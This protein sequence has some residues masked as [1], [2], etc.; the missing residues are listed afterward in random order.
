M[1]AAKK[2]G[3]KEPFNLS[4]RIQWLREY[5]F[6]GD[7]RVWN[8]EFSAFTTGTPWDEVFDETSFLIVPEVYSFFPT[9]RKSFIMAARKID[10]P[11]G[12]FSLS[13]PER[14]AWLMKEAIVNRVPQ[15][16]LPGD[17]IAG[18]RFNVMASRCWS[19]AEAKAR[20]EIL[21]GKG[22]IRADTFKFRD[23]GYGNCGA[24]SGHLIRTIR[25]YSNWAFPASKRI[26]WQSTTPL[27]QTDQ[28][29]KKGRAAQS[30]DCQLRMPVELAMK[31]AALC[32]ELAAKEADSRA[33]PSCS[34]C[35]R[36][37][38]ACPANRQ[39]DFYEA[40]QSLWLTHMLVLTDENY[41]GAGVSFGRIDQY[42]L[43][44]WQESVKRGMDRELCQRNSQVLL[45]ALQLCLRRNDHKQATRA[46]LRVTPALSTSPVL[47][48]TG[49]HDQRAYL[50]VPRGD[51]RDEPHPRTQAERPPA[52]AFAGSAARQGCGYDRI[53]SGRAVF[54]QL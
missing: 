35:K 22:G 5:Y 28:S 24:T 14:R 41:P 4:P 36:I 51:R 54:A 31:Y 7:K 38:S 27:S 15:E 21:L 45:D 8:N 44:Y 6:Q 23:K 1:E 39:T 53:Q 43:P 50:G 40:L 25:A 26:C 17:L 37:S 10:P 2:T 12:F 47:A 16:I 30:N 42:L 18:G 33:K 20:N 11:K 34:P 29:G 46:S 13:I 3:V 9:F 32:G 48:R 52:R 49:G 19:K